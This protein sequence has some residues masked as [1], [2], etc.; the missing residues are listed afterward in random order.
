MLF[1]RN[2]QSFQVFFQFVSVK[3]HFTD[4]GVDDAVF[5]VTVTNLTSF[6]ILNS[7]SNVRSYSTNFRV[8]H[9]AA[10]T[11]NLTQLG[12]QRALHPGKQ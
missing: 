6:S 2:Q 7:F 12:Q 5:V 11:Q 8:W 1:Q 10:R 9:Q 3:I 4:G